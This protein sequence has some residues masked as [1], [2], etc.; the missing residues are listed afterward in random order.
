MKAPQNEHA[1]A[2][3]QDGIRSYAKKICGA[4]SPR[5]ACS[6]TA[7]RSAPSP[8]AHSPSPR[9]NTVS[10][11]TRVTKSAGAALASPKAASLSSSN[12]IGAGSPGG[13]R[14]VGAA[15][16]V[17][18]AGGEWQQY[19]GASA[20]HAKGRGASASTLGGPAKRRGVVTTAD[21]ILFAGRIKGKTAKQLKE[22][23]GMLMAQA[24]VDPA[25]YEF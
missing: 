8:R 12:S 7:T 2:P 14:G 5:G 11:C 20:A 24:G 1:A 6:A 19:G 9:N 10:F 16:C 23:A 21:A 22:L 17:A 4:A 25:R 15:S 18:C 13:A 3:V